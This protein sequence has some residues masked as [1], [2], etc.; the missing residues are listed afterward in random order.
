[1]STVLPSDFESYVQQAV[2]SGR[3]ATAL[4]AMHEALRLLKD[5]DQQAQ[6]LREDIRQGVEQ[7]DRGEGIE[8]DDAGLAGLFEEIEQQYLARKS[9]KPNLS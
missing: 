3:Y 6:R 9:A 2:A 8:Y 5:H 4:D 7:L 1:M